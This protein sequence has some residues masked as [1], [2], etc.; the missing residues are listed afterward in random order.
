MVLR[1]LQKLGGDS[2]DP[3]TSIMVTPLGLVSLI[4]MCPMS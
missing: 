2:F 4:P 1:L 3:F